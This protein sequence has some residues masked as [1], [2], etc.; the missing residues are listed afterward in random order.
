ML[1]VNETEILRNYRSNQCLYRNANMSLPYR[2]NKDKQ[3][4]PETQR[5]ATQ[6]GLGCP[7]CLATGTNKKCAM[8]KIIFCNGLTRAA[9]ARQKS[10]C[11]V[12][13]RRVQ[14]TKQ[15]WIPLI[16][17]L[18][19]PNPIHPFQQSAGATSLL[20]LWTERTSVHVLSVL[21]LK[22]STLYP[23]EVSLGASSTLLMSGYFVLSH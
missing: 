11:I 8:R 14:R 6:H 2:K 21:T 13:A 3:D 17:I 16:S 4:K 9:K 10:T 15:G 18:W 12:P 22:P 1:I 23:L 7:G 5:Q 20:S 19:V